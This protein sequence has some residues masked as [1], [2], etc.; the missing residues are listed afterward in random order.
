MVVI[1]QLRILKEGKKERRKER[2]KGKSHTVPYASGFECSLLY[3]FHTDPIFIV[4]GFTIWFLTLISL[5]NGINT[6]KLFLLS[7]QN[8]IVYVIYFDAKG[9][10]MENVHNV[11]IFF[12]IIHNSFLRSN[13]KRLSI[14]R[15][16]THCTYSC[17][18]PFA[19]FVDHIVYA[20][21]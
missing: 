7:S 12:S 2:K 3:T 19:L 11:C 16:C 8:L 20:N 1:I 9:K 4:L 6:F 13:K 5:P 14:L 15:H 18:W 21:L 17:A 10:G